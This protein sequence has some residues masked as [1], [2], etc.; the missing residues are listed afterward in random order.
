MKP[1]TAKT[2]L[3]K[4]LTEQRLMRSDTKLT[5]KI[6]GPF[7]G[8]L[9]LITVSIQ[10]YIHPMHYQDIFNFASNNGFCVEIVEEETIE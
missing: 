7:M 10:G 5:G 9:V 3:K 6:T 1:F 8:S 4:Y 2:L